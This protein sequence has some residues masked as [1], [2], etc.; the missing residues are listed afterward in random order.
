MVQDVA[1]RR[2]CRILQTDCMAPGRPAL[3]GTR[4]ASGSV[5]KPSGAVAVE[6]LEIVVIVEIREFH[7]EAAVLP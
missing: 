6:T 2:R 1:T 3:Y 4:T 5:R 7:F